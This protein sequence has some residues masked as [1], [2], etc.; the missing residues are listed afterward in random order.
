[1]TTYLEPTPASGAAL[2]QRGLTGPVV[3]LNLLKFRDTA[4]YSATP[5]L[6]PDNPI[7]G[8]EAF[9]L[10]IAHTLPHLRESGGDL[11][12]IGKGG[13]FLIGPAEE[14]WDCV[15]LVRQSSVESFMSF[16]AN[17]AYLDGIG[18]RTAA[19]RDSRLLPLTDVPAPMRANPCTS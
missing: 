9:D 6:T 5:D 12:F 19:I 1:M 4:D 8:A 10:Y 13:P 17:E 16:A 3:M 2:M 11:L 18:H 14:C 7:T 15:M